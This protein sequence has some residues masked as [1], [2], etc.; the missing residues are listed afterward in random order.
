MQIMGQMCLLSI[1]A[2]GE[3][4]EGKCPGGERAI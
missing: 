1:N 3:S 2:S 4:R